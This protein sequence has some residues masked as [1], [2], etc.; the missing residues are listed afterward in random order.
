MCNPNGNPNPVPKLYKSIIEDVIEGVSEHFAEEGV[1]KQV[2][3]EL[4]QLW[5]TKVMQSKATEGFFRDHCNVP[6]FVLQLPQHL[7]QSL[8]TSTE[9]FPCAGLSMD[10]CLDDY[11]AEPS[12]DEI[13]S[14]TRATGMSGNKK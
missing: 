2:F 8:H 5:K 12:V 13:L 11:K 9:F 3:K 6:Q 14:L 7:H 10:I 4:K 1:D